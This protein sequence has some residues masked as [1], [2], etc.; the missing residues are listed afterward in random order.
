MFARP[1][2]LGKIRGIE[3][4]IHYTW[5][6]ALL[7]IT[8]SL[9]LT[10]AEIY[11]SWSSF[12]RWLAALLST[13][14]LFASVLAHELAHSLV[15]LRH[16]VPV[17]SITLFLFGGVAQITR[18]A[19]SPGAEFRIAIAGPAC[20]LALAAFFG[21][22]W[23]LSRRPVE[24]I[25][26]IAGYLALINLM[27]VGFNLVPGFPLD[28]GRVLRSLIWSRT[29]DY[30]LA[31]RIALRGGKGISYLLIAGGIGGTIALSWIGQGLWVGGLWLA[32]VGWFLYT[33]VKSSAQGAKIRQGLKRLTVRSI[34]VSLSF[35]GFPWPT[36][37][38]TQ[39]IRPDDD[40]LSALEKMQQMK[41]DQLTV[42]EGGK[43]VGLLRWEDL[44]RLARWLKNRGERI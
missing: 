9:G 5:F 36:A 6:P 22:L 27:L 4:E 18:E 21:L 10:Y 12:A 24:F 2:R 31:T 41:A 34:M 25:A 30:D 35:T 28:G 11:P 23:F 19:S 32:L 40:L 29:G 33:A 17:K 20:S 39:S 16:D 7:F 1:L 14:L 38:A 3:F 44:A 26:G 42:V 13:L 8:L 15:A 37:S 43:V